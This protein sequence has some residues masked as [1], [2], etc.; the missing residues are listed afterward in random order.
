MITPVTFLENYMNSIS[1]QKKYLSENLVAEHLRKYESNQEDI[2]EFLQAQNGDAIAQ[3]L[4][5]RAW[6]DDSNNDTKVFL[7]RDK[8]TRKIAFF[9]ALNC[10]I[11][12]K[13]LNT[14]KMSFVEKECVEKLIK[15]LRQN[16]TKGLNE[17]EKN[18]TYELLSQ[19]YGLFDEKIEDSDRA[20][21][22]I[23]YAQ[24]QAEIKEERE[25]AVSQTGDSE[26]VKNVQ[27]T[28]PAIDIKFFCKNANYQPHIELDFKFGV[29][30]F[31]EIIVPHILNISELVGCKYVYL[32]AADRSESPKVDG[33]VDN[34]ILYSK[35]YDIDSEDEIVNEEEATEENVKKLVLYYINNLKFRP[36]SD[37]TIL[38]PHFERDCYTLIQDVADLQHKREL[39]WSSHDQD[40]EMGLSSK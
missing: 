8:K 10:G 32:F 15:A 17:E 21:L 3:Y 38:K 16:N 20:S 9:Y 30:V 18:A 23:S 6:N 1:K 19:A 28:Y 4:N 25:E 39:I 22:L 34:P 5:T 40:N 11:L 24:E 2:K 13:D 35:G 12:Y 31:W 7:I 36:V 14:I 33:Q 29:Y 37:Y 27:E 26:F